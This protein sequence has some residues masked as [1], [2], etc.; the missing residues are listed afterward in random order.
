MT[1]RVTGRVQGVGFRAFTRD[2]ARSRNLSGWVRNEPDGSVSAL[3]GGSPADVGDFLTA[4]RRG[5]PA[6]KVDT[7]ETDPADPPAGGFS[8]LH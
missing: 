8:I 2:E 5:P 1:I 3:V 6:A 7:V 4:L